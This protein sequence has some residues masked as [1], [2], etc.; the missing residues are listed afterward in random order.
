[1]KKFKEFLSEEGTLSPQDEAMRR[2]QVEA[3]VMGRYD[4][5]EMEGQSPIRT[6]AEL[7]DY[8]RSV[9]RIAKQRAEENPNLA[10]ELKTDEAV[11]SAAAT[12]ANKVIPFLK[13]SPLSGHGLA[14]KAIPGYSTSALGSGID[15]AL[16]YASNFSRNLATAAYADKAGNPA[17]PLSSTEKIQQRQGK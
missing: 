17:N 1:M 15:T 13:S 7:D 14:K 6:S 3:Q 10:T 16:N 12:A 5:P 4:S 11:A 8:A 9:K 2:K